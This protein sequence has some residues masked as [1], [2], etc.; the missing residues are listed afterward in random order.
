M[1]MKYCTEI[2]VTNPIIRELA[3]KLQDDHWL[4]SNKLYVLLNFPSEIF[5]FKNNFNFRK[6]FKNHYIHT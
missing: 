2:E 6:F 3:S 4:A 1:F 5:N